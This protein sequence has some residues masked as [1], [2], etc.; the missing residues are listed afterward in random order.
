VLT[1]FV[2]SKTLTLI[3]KN[4]SYLRR[5]VAKKSLESLSQEINISKYTLHNIENNEDN[6]EV[7]YPNLKTLLIISSYFNIDI[8]DF[9]SKDL[10]MVEV[11]RMD[12]IEKLD[13]LGDF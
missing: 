10:E 11:E 7:Y 8:A 4:L 12:T 13:R 5:R 9:I 1:V 3:R 6:D 2:G